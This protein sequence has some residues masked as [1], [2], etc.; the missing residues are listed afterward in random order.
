ML[1]NDP[2]FIERA[3]IIREKGTNRSKFLRGQVDK[4]TWVEKGSSYLPSELVAAFLFAQMEEAESITEHRLKLWDT[5]HQWLEPLEAAGK[6]RRP[7][8]P[9]ECK[10]NA[11]MYYL[12]LDDLQVRTEFIRQMQDAEIDCV[13]HYVPLHS[14]PMG[15]H[16]GRTGGNMENTDS[17][18]ER[19]VRF[20]RLAVR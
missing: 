1:V 13:F 5:Y 18:S 14:S 17:L 6:L 7:I 11:H 16:C 10:H 12:L 20:G 4:Y 9:A 3:E 8:I 19:L 2:R 15:S